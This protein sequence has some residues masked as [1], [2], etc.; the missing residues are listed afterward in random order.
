MERS[1]QREEGGVGALEEEQAGAAL[2]VK[3]G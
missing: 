2:G 3:C 1:R